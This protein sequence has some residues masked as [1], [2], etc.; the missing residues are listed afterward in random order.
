MSQEPT[1]PKDNPYH[2]FYENY[3]DTNACTECTGLMPTEAKNREEW[4]AYRQ[5]YD[6]TA[7]PPEPPE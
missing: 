6:F 3:L 7:K 4:D 2:V 5:I 1:N